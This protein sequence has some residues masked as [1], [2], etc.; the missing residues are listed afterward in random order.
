MSC[1]CRCRCRCRCN[2]RRNGGSGRGDSRRRGDF[3]GC[4]SRGSD[5]CSRGTSNWGGSWNRSCGSRQ[6]L[7]INGDDVEWAEVSFRGNLPVFEIE[8]SDDSSC[9]HR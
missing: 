4:S 1:R 7:L 5:R 3:E 9:S 6:A 2:N 8:D